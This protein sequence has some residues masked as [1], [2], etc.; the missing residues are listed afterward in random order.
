MEYDIYI[1]DTIG[2][3]ISAAY[4]KGLLQ[5]Y[6]DKPCN[7]YISSFGGAVA[8]A[9]QIHQMFM[10]HGNVTA[11]VYGFTASAATIIAMGAKKII[12]GEYALMLIHRCSNWVDE[13]G[14]MNAEDIEQVIKS[15]LHTSEELKTIDHVIASIYA[16]R[17][18]LDIA[19]VAAMMQEAKWLTADQCKAC[20]LA[21]DITQ[22]DIKPD[23]V[24]DTLKGR[25]V[26]YGLP[27]PE[28]ER[29]L[30]SQESAGKF[31][32]WLRNFFKKE[33]GIAAHHDE[34]LVAEEETNITNTPKVM[35]KTYEHMSSLLDCLVGTDDAGNATL[36]EAQLS[37][38]DNALAG[39]KQQRDELQA[40]VEAL[41]AQNTALAEEVATLT[42]Q[43]ENLSNADGDETTAIKEETDGNTDDLSSAAITAKNDYELIKNIL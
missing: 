14:Q 37:A 6:K 3:P 4:V 23:G 29:R 19:E 5:D 33:E 9:L 43:V 2:Y 12:M 28:I 17:T 18:S 21:D 25:I 40:S 27:V 1:N 42:E 31:I 24:T 15:L 41:T 30:C 34:T 13:W 22:H 32:E 26:A 39:L 20:G 11:Y 10:E 36:D 7:V 16:A 35:N 38:I 8:D